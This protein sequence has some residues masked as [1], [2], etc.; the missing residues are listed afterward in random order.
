MKI[1]LLIFLMVH[2]LMNSI[3]IQLYDE[4]TIKWFV[5]DIEMFRV[6]PSSFNTIPSL[7]SWA[8]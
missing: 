3:L 2:M 5:D 6:T 1:F 8:I 7:N 4:D